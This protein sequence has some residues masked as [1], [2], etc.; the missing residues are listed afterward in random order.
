MAS[1]QQD[2]QM[3]MMKESMGQPAGTETPPAVV[4]PTA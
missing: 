4:P 3:A 1:K 2:E